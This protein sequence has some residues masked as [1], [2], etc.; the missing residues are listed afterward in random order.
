MGLAGKS[1]VVS[2]RCLAAQV[3]IIAICRAV[4][5]VQVQQ[6][7]LDPAL[8][9]IDALEAQAGVGLPRVACMQ[10]LSPS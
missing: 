3:S 4:Q 10:V 9:A 6:G 5:A 8:E 2:S 7:A 1:I